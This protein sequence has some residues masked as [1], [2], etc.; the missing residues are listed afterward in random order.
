M[1]SNRRLRKQIALW[2]IVLLA[3]R[4]HADDTPAKPDTPPM[5]AVQ[6]A[7]NPQGLWRFVI[8]GAE[9]PLHG[10]GG[11]EAEGL[12]ERLR[13]A[14]GTCV[15]TW[16]A[17]TLDRTFADGETFLDRAHRLGLMVLAGIWVEHERHGFDYSDTSAVEAQRERTRSV[18]R[19]HRHHPAILAWSIG[20]EM[21]GPSSA[22]GS[23][24]ALREVE[25]LVRIAKEED[26]SRPVMTIIAFHP[27]KIRNIMNLCPSIDLLGLNSY[28]GASGIGPALEAAGWTKPFAVTEFG[29]PGFWEVPT[30]AWGAPLEPDSQAKARTYYATQVLVTRQQTGHERCVGTFA[31]LWGWKQERTATWFGMFLPTLEK[32]PTVDA[33]TRAWTGQWPSNRCP[34]ITRITSESSGALVPPGTHQVAEVSVI[35]PE[36]DALSYHWTIAAESTAQSE[37]GDAEY[38]PA[39]FPDLITRNGEPTCHFT[40]PTQPGPYR[41]FLVVRDG[42]RNAA[43]ANIPFLVQP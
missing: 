23:E 5:P 22:T 24:P 19:R 33:M 29:V 6:L 25:N 20:N 35:D 38:V 37:G 1:R 12:L 43:T 40:T 8:D 32:L 9:F 21:E 27:G 34:K 36:G 15:R 42:H 41:L 14:G 7:A 17:E 28:G 13:E 16:G 39:E 18:I 4:I 11:A 31:F 3:V 26:P 10:A 2:T 30:T